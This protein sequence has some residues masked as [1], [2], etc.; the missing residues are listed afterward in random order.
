MIAKG[1]PHNN[2]PYL[3]R[4]LAVDSKG[5]ERAELAEVRGF[6]TDNIFD[7]LALGQLQ[8]EGTK[9]QN[10]FFHVQ[11]RLP[12]E[13][14]LT[15]AQWRRV[16]ERIERKL[17][18]RDQ[19]RAIVFHQKAGRPHMHVV[20]SRL[21]VDDN[22]AIE[23]GLFKRK[24]KEVCR[25]LEK[26]MGLKQ[27]RNERDPS[28]KTQAAKRG[29][30]EESRRLKT[31]LKA[32]RESIRIA[33]DRSDSGA[34]LSANLEKQGLI[35]AH[36]DRRDFV[37]ID[38][39]GGMH[40]LGKR[41]TGATAPETR[42]RL[43]DIDAS[44]LPGIEEARAMQRDR[45]PQGGQEAKVVEQEAAVEA[46][47]IG[48]EEQAKEDIRAAEEARQKALREEEE[49]R[50]QAIKDQDERRQKEIVS[51]DQ[52][53]Q[54]AAQKEEE[55]RRAAFKE[56]AE[57]QVEQAR[58]MEQQQLRL[59]A[60]KAELQRQAEEEKKR[61]EQ[62]RQT[63]AEADAAE[64][65]IRNPNYRYG[66]AL[67][68]HYD[69]KDPYGSLARSAMAEYGSFL[70][71]REELN[72]QIA[73]AKDPAERQALVLRQRIESAEYMAITSERIATQSEIIV[74]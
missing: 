43:A 53:R 66:Q 25:A 11:V 60:Y 13:E 42:A 14:E 61:T 54:E 15:G 48:K 49:Q 5:N 24:L 29:E 18:F 28:T 22:R 3:A 72:R 6:A 58:I 12:K 56:Q 59:D 67:A 9:C 10:P 40:A 45:Q 57:R 19:P 16:A 23:S 32:I 36:G 38:A 37:I 21:S 65:G 39:K 71:D 4:Y 69:I 74:G 64:L 41:I 44:H 31:D 17:G 73:Q 62:E 30:F 35:L 50:Q 70:R 68:Q 55:E 46:G 33:W 34:S 51:A 1:N 8:A 27:V 26:E 7:A 52:S 2:G 63:R 47:A 20:W